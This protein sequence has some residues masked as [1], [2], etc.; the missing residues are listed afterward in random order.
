MGILEYNQQAESIYKKIEDK[1]GLAVYGSR[2]HS[3]KNMVFARGR[4]ADPNNLTTKENRF[5]YP[6]PEHCKMLGRANYPMHPVMYAGESPQI[7]ADELNLNINDLFHL[8]I[9]Y[10]PKPVNFEY[11][12][13]LHDGIA[14]TNK[15]R[16]TLDEFKEVFKNNHPTSHPESPE[17]VWE[18]VQSA[19]M[20]FRGNDY[21]ETAAIAHHW[22]YGRGI[23]AIL[24]PSLHNDDYCNFALNPKFVDQNLVLYRVH[25]CKWLGDNLEL[26]HTGYLDSGNMI[27]RNTSKED[28]DELQNVYTNLQS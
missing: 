17:K 19:A 22:L 8:A 25:A 15:W 3:N 7:I 11:L 9:F 13:L 1:Y 6:P 27:W 4:T 28:H 20:A 12:L 2:N 14:V 26:H 21:E 18:R 16:K 23:D 5:S 10:T 24:Y